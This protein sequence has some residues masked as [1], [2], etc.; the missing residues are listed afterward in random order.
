RSGA[1]RHGDG[2]SRILSVEMLPGTS[3]EPGQRVTVRIRAQAV[4]D[5]ESPVVG[6]LI[7]NRFGIDV[8]GTNTRIERIDLGN[9]AAGDMFEV[10]FAFECLLT[11]QEYTLTAATQYPEGFSQDWL[12]DVVSFSVVD[13]RDIAGLASLPTEVNWR[14]VSA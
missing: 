4:Q 14:R 11:R 9:I 5:L 8:F 2:A 13:S 1:Q 3:I 10:E 7:R 6:I 12:D